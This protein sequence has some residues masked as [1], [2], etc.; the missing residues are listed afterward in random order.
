M[1]FLKKI[2]RRTFE[3]IAYSLQIFEFDALGFIVDN[4][5]EVLVAES[6]LYN[7]YF[8]FP[9]YSRISKILSFIYSPL[10]TL[11]YPLLS[12]YIFDLKIS[13]F[14]LGLVRSIAAPAVS[15][16]QPD[17]FSRVTE[18]NSGQP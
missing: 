3:N 10:F 18:L 4:V 15:L 11:V 9:F 13:A 14:A 5:V 7:Q 1:V 17:V 2:V 12:L 16:Y 8:V 6:E